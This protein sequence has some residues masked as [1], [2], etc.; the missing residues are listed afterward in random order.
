[1]HS[2]IC[3][4]NSTY[5]NRDPLGIS[6]T[7]GGMVAIPP[8]SAGFLKLRSTKRLALKLLAVISP[9]A[10]GCQA[11]VHAVCSKHLQLQFD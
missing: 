7:Y 11:V 9:G 1:M 8:P 10:Q 5:F 4:V 3:V 2:F 6:A